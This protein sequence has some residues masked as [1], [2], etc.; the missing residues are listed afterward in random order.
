VLGI[1]FARNESL[2]DLLDGFPAEQGELGKELWE[3]VVAAREVFGSGN[4]SILRGAIERVCGDTIARERYFGS[5][6]S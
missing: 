6:G 1:A 5:S 3:C 2:K 4:L